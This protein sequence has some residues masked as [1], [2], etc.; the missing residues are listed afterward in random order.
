MR[1]VAVQFTA[2]KQVEVI[3]VDVGAP[4]ADEALVRSLYSG[5]SSGTEMLVYR[6]EVPD[7]LELDEAITSLGGTFS[8]PVR[9][10]YSC[11]G[12]VEEGTADPAPGTLVFCLHPHQ[13]IF[14]A[15]REDL[16]VL[17][18]IDPRNATLFPFVE[19]ALQISLE[20]GG[21]QHEHVVV[22]G[23]GALGL[24]TAGLLARAGARVLAS[25][26]KEWRR[27]AAGA[28]DLAAVAPDGLAAAVREVT[29]G[30]GAPLVVE[31]SGD[32]SVLR[33]ALPLLAHEGMCL[34]ASWY[35]IKPAT[36]PLGGDFHRR[37]LTIRSTQ[38]SSIPAALS[39][40][41]TV[42]RR[43]LVA[44]ELLANLPLDVLAT[45]EFPVQDAPAA[46]RA[47][48]R[49]SEG[50]IHAALRYGGR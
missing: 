35:G 7:D 25:D 15:R 20:A 18:D 16:V 9:Y 27:R 45:H 2:P 40:S 42:A 31:A 13:E 34:V 23:L 36:L 12:V 3:E 11:V 49:G 50:L 41:W 28:L 26:P 33:S 39:G 46:F 14:T 24:L 21:V 5:I 4:G 47:V 32:P 22:L 8:Y 10:G 17:P 6:G 19:T 29:G 38:V 1:S 48:D 43:R 30:R 44:R 37:R